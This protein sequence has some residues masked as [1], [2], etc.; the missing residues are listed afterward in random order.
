M[1]RAGFEVQRNHRT[2]ATVGTK[3]VLVA[4]QGFA[5]C[6]WIISATG[7]GSEPEAR[8]KQPK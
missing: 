5:S 4:D 1:I 7:L 2:V 3:E 6:F 8:Q